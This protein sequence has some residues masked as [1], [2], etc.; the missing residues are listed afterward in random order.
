M[1]EICEP[2]NLFTFSPQEG[3]EIDTNDNCVSK[4]KDTTN[5]DNKVMMHAK[6]IDS[7]ENAVI[8]RKIDNEK[9]I[10]GGFN[11]KVNSDNLESLQVIFFLFFHKIVTPHNKSLYYFINIKGKFQTGY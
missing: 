3:Y 6:R 11:V 5:I 7:Y 8:E 2:N 10:N 4:I 1:T 9:K